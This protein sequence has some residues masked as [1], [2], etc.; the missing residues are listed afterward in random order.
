MFKRCLKDV[1]VATKCLKDVLKISWLVWIFF[2]VI[3]KHLE[4]NFFPQKFSR[5]FE[6]LRVGTRRHLPLNIL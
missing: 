4:L 1:M 6:F 2:A 3:L 5:M